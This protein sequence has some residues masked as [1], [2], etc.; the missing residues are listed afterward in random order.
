MLIPIHGDH[1]E[2]RKIRRAVDAMLA[3]DIIGY[4]TDTV[5]ALGCDLLN[6]R[7]IDRLYQ[8]KG[9]ERTQQLALVCPDLSEIARYAVVET[10]A[11]RLLRRLLPGPYTFILE[12]TREVPKTI[13]SKR[14]TVGIRVPRHET[15]LA[16]ARA[17]GHPL[18]STSAAPH[19]AEAYTDPREIDLRFRGLSL[20]LDAGP[21]GVVPT[22]VVDLTEGRVVREGAGPVEELF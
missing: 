12:A 13:Q 15:T 8:I 18:L 22:T 17:L 5:Y 4:P 11:Y 6:K 3:G 20:V 21:G 14:K 1:P 7:A 10:Q 9:M 19:G 16:L 2:P